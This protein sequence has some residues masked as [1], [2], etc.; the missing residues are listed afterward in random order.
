M[1]FG[2]RG[3]A[4]EEVTVRGDGRGSGSGE[5][6]SRAVFHNP[7]IGVVTVVPDDLR[8]VHSIFGNSQIGGFRAVCA[9][10]QTDTVLFV[11]VVA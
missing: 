2:F 5:V 8:L 11:I 10:V 3:E 7:G 6:S 1:V 4:G 9:K